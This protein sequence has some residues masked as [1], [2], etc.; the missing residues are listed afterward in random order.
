[1]I[2]GLHDDAPKRVTRVSAAAIETMRLR[3]FIWNRSAGRITT[4]TPP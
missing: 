1:V 3:V 4:T 2:T